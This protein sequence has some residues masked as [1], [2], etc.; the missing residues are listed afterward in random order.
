MSF[1]RRKL[2]CGGPAVAAIFAVTATLW[3]VPVGDTWLLLRLHM[4]IQTKP[5]PHDNINP[6]ILP[7]ALGIRRAGL[8]SQAIPEV[9][10]LCRSTRSHVRLHAFMVLALFEE[11]AIPAIP[12]LL[13]MGND[14]SLP[15]VTRRDASGL[16]DII[17]KRQ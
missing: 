2:I 15:E 9:L 14:K 6:E 1:R 7:T 5:E 4:R 8:A 11:E 17:Q 12:E 16:A 3:H 10:K 13:R